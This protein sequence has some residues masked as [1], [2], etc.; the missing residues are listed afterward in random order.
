[1][2]SRL[3]PAGE[4]AFDPA[5]EPEQSDDREC[6]DQGGAEESGG[7]APQRIS[8][9]RGA[10]VDDRLSNPAPMRLRQLEQPY[11]FQTCIAF[12]DGHDRHA[13]GHKPGQ[14]IFLDDAE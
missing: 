14:T 12:S 5:P 6:Q 13:A 1:M 10:V 7:R 3:Q 2:D 4:K 8:G 9:P 11:L